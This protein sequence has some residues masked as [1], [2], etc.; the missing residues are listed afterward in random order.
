LSVVK[1]SKEMAKGIKRKLAIARRRVSE[2]IRGLRQGGGIY[3]SG[4][5]SEGY[6]GGYRDALDD[7]LLAL[8]GVTPQRRGYWIENSW[9][10]PK[11]EE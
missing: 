4:T 2:E 10:E 1:R 6:S 5:A 3:A 11:E 8:N 7:V 9:L